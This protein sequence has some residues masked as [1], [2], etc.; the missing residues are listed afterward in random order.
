MPRIAPQKTCPK[1][2]SKVHVRRRECACGYSFKPG[3]PK[4]EVSE[5]IK[6]GAWVKT[7]KNPGLPE[8]IPK[9]RKFTN[10]ELRDVIA[11]EGIGYCVFDYIPADKIEDQEVAKVWQ[12]TYDLF[13]RIVELLD[14]N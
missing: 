10:E 4:V 11:E 12:E 14:R 9:D 5:E 7:L 13:T 8:P 2:S 3:A 6:Q 1:C